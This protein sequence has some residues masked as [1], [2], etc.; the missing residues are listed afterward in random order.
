M[1]GAEPLVRMLLEYQV[2]VI[3]GVP[4]DTSLPLYEALF[5]ARRKIRFEI[6]SELRMDWVRVAH[7]MGT[8]LEKKLK[9][10]CNEIGQEVKAC[11]PKMLRGKPRFEII[12]YAKEN[13]I[14]LIVMA[15]HGLSGWEHALFGSTAERVLRE[16]PCPVRV[17][18]KPR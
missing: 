18:R 10:F 2:E 15:S 12:R 17:I 1:K 7:N 11:L 3:F 4:G 8:E 16:S 6:S 5:H 9:E 14:D 13:N